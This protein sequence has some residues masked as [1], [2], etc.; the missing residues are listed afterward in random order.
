MSQTEDLSSLTNKLILIEY[1][2]KFPLVSN[3]LGMSMNLVYWYRDP[4]ERIKIN[5]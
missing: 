1:S 5:I 2:E 3:I 4:D